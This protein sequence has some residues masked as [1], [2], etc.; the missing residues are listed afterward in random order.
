MM[1]KQRFEDP[2]V[3]FRSIPFWSLNDKLEADE[4]VRQIDEMKKAGWGGFFLHARD[5]RVTPYLSDEWMEMIAACVK[6]AEELGMDAWLYDEDKWPSGFAG[7]IVPRKGADYRARALALGLDKRPEAEKIVA[8]F[9][10]TGDDAWEYCEIPPETEE[11]STAYLTERIAPMGE[12]WFN[13]TCYVDLMNPRVTD[14]FI[15]CTHEAYRRLFGDEFGGVIPGIFTDEPTYL[16]HEPR[17]RPSVPWTGA[18]PEEFERRRGYDLIPKLISLFF[19]A[20]EY[21]KIRYDFYRTCTEL[22]LEN[23]TKRVFDWCDQAGFELTGHFLEEDTLTSQVKRIGAAMPHYEYM[24]RPGV[25]N[26]ERVTKNLITLKQC[27]SAASQFGRKRT[28]SELFG[29]SGQSFSFAGRKWIADWHFVLGINTMNPHLSLYSMRGLRKRDYPPNIFWQQPWW[30]DNKIIADYQARMCYA[31]SLGKRRVDVLVIH[32]IESAWSVFDPSDC[33]PTDNLNGNLDRLCHDLLSNHVD[34]EFGDESIIERHGRVEGDRFVVGDMAYRVVVLPHM[35]T[36]RRRTLD[37]LDEFHKAGG[38]IVCVGRKPE[39]LEGVVDPQV[40]ER[41]AELVL[42]NDSESE[43]IEAIAEGL[44]RI[45][46]EANGQPA[47]SIWVHERQVERGAIVLFAN[48]DPENAVD[49][50]IRIPRVGKI[51]EWDAATG[52]TRPMGAEVGDGTMSISKRFEPAGSLL[53]SIEDGEPA[54]PKEEKLAATSVVELGPKWEMKRSGPN[55]LVLDFCRYRELGRDDW[56]DVVPVWKAR[57]A[58]AKTDGP[59]AARF[60]FEVEEIPKGEVFLVAETPDRYSIRLN[61]EAVDTKPVSWW[62]DKSFAMLKLPGLAHGQNTIKL[63]CPSSKGLEFEDCY[64]VGD[65][66]VRWRALPKPIITA[67]S[68][69]YTGGDLADFGLPFYTGD[70]TL[71]QV[72]HLDTV[73]GRKAIL[74]FDGLDAIVT[75]VR[76]NGKDAGIIVWHPH[77][78]DVTGLLGEGDNRIEITLTSSLRNL[79]GPNHIAGGEPLWTG[80]GQFCDEERWIDEYQL[81]RFGF[82][83]AKIALLG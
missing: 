54:H 62:I 46:V 76:V 36:L 43:A 8:A 48:T 28:L 20:G 25:D 5:G 45:T 67:A 30:K 61:D 80:P 50:T 6:R 44:D 18:L 75:K 14:A 81:V 57:E 23:Y 16:E 17:D 73:E 65:F 10:K 68:P 53:I 31:V 37:L 78:L 72:I 60:D 38:R 15:E 55:A 3:E 11:G 4:L 39:A 22:F 1:D 13:G 40:A 69:E 9:A 32:P 51:T 52:E 7:G 63:T 34:F 19:P 70:V 47:R 21:K 59:F 56:S 2:P 58:S 41:T 24:Q 82:D 26:L 33:T 27:T 71:S 35:A 83:G 66:G 42:V 49:T 77:E 74:S 29:C 12:A 79:L 64:I